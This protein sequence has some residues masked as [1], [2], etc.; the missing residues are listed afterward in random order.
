MKRKTSKTL[1]SESQTS[2]KIENE[3]L[4]EMNGK[5]LKTAEEM[6]N[7][8]SEKT[9]TEKLPIS[10]N[11]ENFRKTE[12]KS[13]EEEFIFLAPN[14]SNTEEFEFE[15]ANPQELY[16]IPRDRPV[17][18]YSDGVYDMFHYG[19]MRC[20]MQAKNLFPNVQLIVGVTNDELTLQNK[21]N[22]ILNEKERYESVKHCK[23]VD[24]VIE[25][26]PWVIS[27]EFLIENRIDF[28]CHDDLPYK[29]DK[30]DDIYK[31]LKDINKFIPTR[32]TKGISTTDI[33]TKIVKDYD[34]FVRRQLERGIDLDELNLPFFKKESFLM[35]KRLKELENDL[36]NEFYD[37]KT[38]LRTAFTYWERISNELIDKFNERFTIKIKNGIRNGLK[39]SMRNNNPF[40]K[41]L[42]KILLILARK[43]A[44]SEGEEVLQ[45]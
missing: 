20:L 18:I 41:I 25:N 39:N 42:R 24:E 1:A 40:N 6:E 16:K 9:E 33:I 26:A 22:L 23:Y 8:K 4:N 10:E 21:G 36:K 44:I 17:R 15:S 45:E 35:K 3:E 32:R 5:R 34:L 37:I 19:H 29:S 11:E 12:E 43:N 14:Y 30:S 13:T 2:D 27:N 7:S 28:V 38:E 31:Y